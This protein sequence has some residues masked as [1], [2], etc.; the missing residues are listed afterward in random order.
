[1]LPVLLS[2]QCLVRFIEPERS[3]R[4]FLEGDK[5]IR[6]MSNHLASPRSRNLSFLL[7]QLGLGSEDR[8][9]EAGR[10]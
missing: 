3:N 5:R 10:C 8:P 9:G 7:Q 4:S 2:E 1:M 6:T